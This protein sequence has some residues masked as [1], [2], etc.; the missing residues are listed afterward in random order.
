MCAQR[1]FGLQLT[2]NAKSMRQLA[3]KIIIGTQLVGSFPLMSQASVQSTS[4]PVASVTMEDPPDALKP[5][6]KDN[7][8]VQMAFKDFD[9]RRFDAAD[10]E[11]GLSIKKWKELNR[12]RDEIV[13]LLK[14]RANARLDNKDFKGSVADND[15]AI[16]LMSV[17]GKKADG[18]AT[19]PEYPG[20]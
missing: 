8:M 14:G 15:E 16:E 17:D 10:K 18:T 9:S 13:S 20:K 12:P 4:L 11:F 5:T 2:N 6:D 1:I 19:Y 3:S 7:Q